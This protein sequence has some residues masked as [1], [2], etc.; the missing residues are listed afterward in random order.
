MKVSAVVVS[1]GHAVQLE[2][3]LPTLAPQVDEIVVIANVPGSVEKVP[4]GVRVLEN[5]RPLSLSAN[6]NLGIA[7]TSGE[8]VLNVNP[9]AIAEADAVAALVAFADGHA[10][11]GIAGP[12]M[13]WPDG[14]WQP[15]RRRFPT[16]GGT[17]VRRTPIR[18]LRPPY[19]TQREHYSLDVRA[20]E[21]VQAD[22]MLGAFLL[23][24]RAMLD[25]IGGWDAGFRHYCEDIDLCYR[26]M[27]A[28]WERWYVPAAVVTHDYA[29]VIDRRF[30][31]LHTLWH[32]RGMARF[33]RKHP[34]RLRAL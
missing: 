15:S 30:L 11:C 13:R 28:G 27:R 31:S 32:A 33:V 24:R 22:W 14:S 4:T 17:L 9:D 26:A 19:E 5:P 7:A 12:Q 34:E 16:V 8:Y 2:R 29:A 20:T 1:H 6:V 23:M 10:R 18:R 21:P 3:S 25:E